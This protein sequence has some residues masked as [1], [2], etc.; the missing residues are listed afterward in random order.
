MGFF[1][2]ELW[3]GLE[4]GKAPEVPINFEDKAII[5]ISVALLIVGIIIILVSYLFFHK[6]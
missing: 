4:D 5:T 2:S 1:Q 3:K 6:S